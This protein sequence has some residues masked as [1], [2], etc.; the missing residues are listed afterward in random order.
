MKQ[1][2]V[3]IAKKEMAFKVPGSRGKP[4]CVKI[5]DRFLV[6][7]PSYANTVSVKIDREK[8]AHLNVG[9]LFAID[10]INEYFEIGE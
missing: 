4:V 2:T 1:F 5:G 10:V 6:T 8:K 3:L 9:Y 7:S